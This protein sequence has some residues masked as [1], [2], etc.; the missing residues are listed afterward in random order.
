MKEIKVTQNNEVINENVRL[1]MVA[2]Q[3]FSLF[4]PA[5]SV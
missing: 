3:W 4:I 2:E 1:I 5:N